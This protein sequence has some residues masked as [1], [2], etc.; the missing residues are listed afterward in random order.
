MFLWVYLLGSGDFSFT[1]RKK[2]VVAKRYVDT[3]MWDDPWFQD[4]PLKHKS[5]WLYLFCKCDEA[6]VWKVNKRLAEFQLESSFEWDKIDD[7]YNKGKE[8]IHFFDDIWFLV[9]FIPFQYGE[10]IFKSSHSF[11]IRLRK[12][13]KDIGYKYPIDTL[14]NRLKEEEQEQEEEQEEEREED[15]T[16]KTK[17]KVRGKAKIVVPKWE[18][19]LDYALSRVPNVNQQQ[20]KLKYEAWVMDGWKD[21]K[22]KKIKNWKS[23]V[24]HNITYWGTQLPSSVDRP[25]AQQ[26]ESQQK[27]LY[28][29]D[30]RL[31]NSHGP[32]WDA[33]GKPHGHTRFEVGK[34][35]KD[36]S[37]KYGNYSKEVPIPPVEYP[38]M[39][40]K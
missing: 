19:F 24:N 12:K 6:G 35:R 8:R 39:E 3:Q 4:L 28:G 18:E 1:G 27:A 36:Y 31:D 23:K 9:D 29:H 20:M 14:S 34:W 38:S 13:I 33:I 17:P 11:H 15:Q 30:Y 10:K 26:K 16:F 37:A 22:G 25:D 40:A 7:I 32:K 2:G 5:L 21:G